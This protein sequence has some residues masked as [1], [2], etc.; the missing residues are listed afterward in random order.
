MDCD[1]IR[2]L[3][4]FKDSMPTVIAQ[5]VSDALAQADEQ[6]KADADTELL[7]LRNKLASVEHFLNMDCEDLGVKMFQDMVKGA[8]YT[9]K[10][11][12]A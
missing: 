12:E 9:E 3:R 11:D 7:Q 1:T 10:G 8:I 2:E 4:E 5:A 6:H